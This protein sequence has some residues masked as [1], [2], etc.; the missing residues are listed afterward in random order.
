MG[1]NTSLKIKAS[2]A[3]MIIDIIPRIHTFNFLDSSSKI[4]IDITPV[5]IPN[6][7]GYQSIAFKIL[8]FS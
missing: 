1:P 7:I 6:I 4:T 5:I 3:T 8:K 2:M